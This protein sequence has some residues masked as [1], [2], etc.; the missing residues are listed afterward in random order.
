MAD[1][2]SVPFLHNLGRPRV[3][4]VLER[5]EWFVW[6]SARPL[7]QHRF[8]HHFLGGG[9]DAVETALAAYVRPDGG[10]AYALEA[11]V[12]GPSS[13]PLA[14][15]AALNVLDEIGRCDAARTARLRSHL[16]SLTSPDGGLP[17]LH[18]GIAGY[19]SSAVLTVR[20]N[21][22]GSLLATGV[23]VG[24]LHRNGIEDPWLDAATEFCWQAVD[25]L[26]SSHPYEVEAALAF[27]DGV[28]DR[29]R[30]AKSAQRLGELVRDQRLV[31]TDPA[32]A[33]EFPV[34]PAY[35]AGEYHYV[36]DVLRSPRSLAREWFTEQEVARCLDH[37]AAVQQEDGGWPV[38]WRLWAPGSAAEW[39]PIVTLD[40]LRTLRA[41]GRL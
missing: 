2:P 24:R 3:R 21:P 12:R 9:A 33:E 15:A 23:I 38:L 41:H 26:T 40:A 29:G 10:Y 37:L 31:V 25:G 35:A 5:A 19:P 22:P 11:D 18:P 39:R 14:A 6:L 13:Q 32:R 17:T 20:P 7:E 16:P 30:A 8:A 28:P 34:H 27:L 36:T 1:A 4:T